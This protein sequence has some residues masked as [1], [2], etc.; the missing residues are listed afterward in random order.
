MAS[1]E[2]TLSQLDEALLLAPANAEQPSP[3]GATS[4]MKRRSCD[5]QEGAVATKHASQLAAVAR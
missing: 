1:S 4:E 5:D 2:K 3:L